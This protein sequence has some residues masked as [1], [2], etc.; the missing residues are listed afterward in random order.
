MM[1]ATSL[2]S[3][4]K[5]KLTYSKVYKSQ[6]YSSVTFYMCNCHAD[7]DYRTFLMLRVYSCAPSIEYPP[8]S[9]NLELTFKWYDGK[10][11]IKERKQIWRSNYQAGYSI[12]QT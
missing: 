10:Q 4:L 3:F 2:T 1:P 12:L 11:N 9:I 6:V 8:L 5:I 7:K